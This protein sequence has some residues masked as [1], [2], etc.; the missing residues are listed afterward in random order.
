MTEETNLK[1]F[2][3]QTYSIIRLVFGGEKLM[4]KIV[5][6]TDESYSEAYNYS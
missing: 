2:E 6:H 4:D 5:R 3:I 1:L